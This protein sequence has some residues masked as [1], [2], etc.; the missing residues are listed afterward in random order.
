MDVNFLGA[1]SLGLSLAASYLE[2]FEKDFGALG[3]IDYVGTAGGG[4]GAAVYPELRYN[5]G[6]SL[7]ATNWSVTWNMRWMDEAD[8]LYRPSNITDDGVAEDIFYHDLIGTYAINNVDLTV[9]IDNVLDEEPPQFHSG[10]NM[11]T[12]PGVYDTIGRRAWV[13]ATLNF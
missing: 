2:E 7:M 9:G 6:V 5:T 4:S 3:M 10:F 12:A 1:N 11:H 13:K 8:D